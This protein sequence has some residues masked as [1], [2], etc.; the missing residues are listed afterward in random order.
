MRLP[1]LSSML[2]SE[3]R[4][5]VFSNDR[6]NTRNNFKRICV[7]GREGAWW[8]GCRPCSTLDAGQ[9]HRME[10]GVIV[11]VHHGVQRAEDIL[12][13]GPVK[14]ELVR[15]WKWSNRR[16]S[17]AEALLRSEALGQ[18]RSCSESSLFAGSG[19][20]SF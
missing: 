12:A 20:T 6:F 13:S 17:V 19:K 2:S 11:T 7:C 3:F 9:W 5:G 14:E 10:K 16:L 15:K 4:K 8:R 18:W 1:F